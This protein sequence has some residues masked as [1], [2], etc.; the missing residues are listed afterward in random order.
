MFKFYRFVLF[1]A[2]IVSGFSIRANHILGGNF[3]LNNTGTNGYYELKLNLFLEFR[4]L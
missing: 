1:F 4:L 2:L 3:E